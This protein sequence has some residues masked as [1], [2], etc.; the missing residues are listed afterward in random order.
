MVY[1]ISYIFSLYIE[2]NLPIMK[3]YDFLI[4]SN[5]EQMAQIMLHGT[6]VTKLWEKDCLFVLYSLG[7]FFFEMEYHGNTKSAKQ[8][9]MLVRKHVFSTGVRMEKYLTSDLAI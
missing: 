4:L 1:E 9:A 8:E 2:V 3:L 7:T 5:E 6:L